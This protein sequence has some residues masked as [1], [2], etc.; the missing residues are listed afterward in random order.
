MED[1]YGT[2][3]YFTYDTINKRYSN[4]YSY[5][6]SINYDTTYIYYNDNGKIWYMKN[7]AYSGTAITVFE[8]NSDGLLSKLYA[9]TD[10]S[11]DTSNPYYISA[12]D[13]LVYN[14]KKQIASSYTI[15]ADGIGDYFNFYFDE[16]NDSLLKKLKYYSLSATGQFILNDTIEYSSYDNRPNPFNRYF[17]NFGFYNGRTNGFFPLPRYMIQGP[18][19]VFST[20]SANNCTRAKGL[21][22]NYTYNSDLMPVKCYVGSIATGDWNM[23]YYKK[24]HK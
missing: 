10:L 13:S 6:K 16:N 14:D 20:L 19:N 4:W 21:P 8:Y 11:T 12:Y 24:V 18:G 15:Y 22:I 1:N 9:K 23:F 17:S 7:R 3:V 5:Y 2:K